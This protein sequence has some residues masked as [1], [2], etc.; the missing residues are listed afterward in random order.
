LGHEISL[1]ENITRTG[2]HPADEFE[3]FRRFA[4]ERGLSAEEIDPRF[5]KSAQHVQQRLR[6]GAVAPA[7]MEHYRAGSLVLTPRRPTW[8]LGDNPLLVRSATE[9]WRPRPPRD[10]PAA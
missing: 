4:E 8:R 5:G 10:E 7:L 3:A 2:L 1:D 6:L 9:A